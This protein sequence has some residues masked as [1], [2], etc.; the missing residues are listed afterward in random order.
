[1]DKD[2]RIGNLTTV[3]IIGLSV[4]LRFNDD[5]IPAVSKTPI[6]SKSSVVYLTCFTIGALVIAV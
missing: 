2:Q 5:N 1:M 6:I 3:H 4:I